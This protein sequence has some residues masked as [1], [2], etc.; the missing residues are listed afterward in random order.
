M[1]HHPTPL[2][3]LSP[4]WFAIVMGLSGLALAWQR[5]G[6][7][8][9]GLAG[10]CALL[11]GALAALVF[12]LLT[13]LSLLRWRRYPQALAEDLRHPVR[14]A[15]AAAVPVSLILLATV[16]VVLA[17][18]G[19]LVAGLWM[20]GAALQ[21]G[22]TVWTLGRW[23]SPVRAEGLSWPSITPLLFIPAVGNVLV[24]L[25]GAPLGQLAWS[26]AQLG[27]GVLL[28]PL[29]LALLALRI[30]ASGLWP[31]PL[32]PTTFITVAPPAAIGLAL[33]QLGAPILLGW[34]FW[35]VALFFVLWSG[36]VLRRSLPQPFGL[37]FWALSFPLAAFSALSLRLAMDAAP[38]FQTMA[39]LLLV[40]VTLVIALLALA[41][42]KGLCSG[43]LPAP[44][45]AAQAAQ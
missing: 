25:A 42:V 12:G 40:A 16:A 24:P 5:A 39:C 9:G 35:G 22:V 7:F 23:L 2:K 26:A 36:L 18:P 28:W 3:S 30:A 13:V 33:L 21:L 11:L 45:P 27:V 43:R 14:H 10:A 4:G 38:W 41:T 37:T 32:L 6:P 29:V 15:F 20:V 19:Q 44:E 31:T 34:S 1:L 17:G 8:M